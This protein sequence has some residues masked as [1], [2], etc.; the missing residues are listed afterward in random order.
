MILNTAAGETGAAEC[1]TLQANY[2]ADIQYNIGTFVI[3]NYCANLSEV[4][5]ACNKN[6]V[7]GYIWHM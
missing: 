5:Q 7:F 1:H 4:T 3:G 2:P 6:G